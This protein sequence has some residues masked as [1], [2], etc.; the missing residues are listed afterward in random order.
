MKLGSAWYSSVHKSFY[1]ASVK[2]KRKRENILGYNS[3]FSV[4]V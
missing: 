4:G 1:F 2:G 3:I